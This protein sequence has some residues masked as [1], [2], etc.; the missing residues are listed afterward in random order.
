MITGV[1]VLIAM[2]LGAVTGCVLTMTL[3]TV[4]INHWTE[5][6]MRKV[7]Y[8]RGEADRYREALERVQPGDGCETPGRRR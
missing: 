2:F 6:M 5:W 1:I 3:A 7:R 4:A 8:W